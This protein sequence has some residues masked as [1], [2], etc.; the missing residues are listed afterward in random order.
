MDEKQQVVLF[1]FIFQDMCDFEITQ[2]RA[3]RVH[4]ELYMECHMV[5]SSACCFLLYIQ[6]SCLTSHN[7]TRSG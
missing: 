6:L 2:T 3:Q 5:P 1:I 4:T 7:I